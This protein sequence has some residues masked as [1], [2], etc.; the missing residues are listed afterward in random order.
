MLSAMSAPIKGE[1]A[2]TLSKLSKAGGKY[3]AMGSARCP[4]QLQSKN[5]LDELST[6]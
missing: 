1:V 4:G 2:S 3:A 5:K 6:L